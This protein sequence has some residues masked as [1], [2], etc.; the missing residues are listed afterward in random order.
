M[1]YHISFPPS[2]KKNHNE[3]NIQK[4]NDQMRHLAIKNKYQSEG[5]VDVLLSNINVH[6]NSKNKR[7][8]SVL[9]S[10][11]LNSVYVLDCTM[12]NRQ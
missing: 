8:S 12:N 4:M 6:F 5:C 11:P 9:H 2:T 1:I 10:Y 3:N 7:N